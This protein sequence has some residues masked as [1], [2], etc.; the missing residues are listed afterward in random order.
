MSDKIDW[1][2]VWSKKYPILAIYREEVDVF[3]YAKEL[4]YLLDRLKQ[5]YGYDELNALLVLKDIL[6][7]VWK[8]RKKET[9]RKT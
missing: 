7:V 8:N 6:T 9:H 2:K 3:V 5:E 4:R 1:S